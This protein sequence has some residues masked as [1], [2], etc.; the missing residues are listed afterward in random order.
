MLHE[1]AMK[2]ALHRVFISVE[3]NDTM[4]RLA[5][6]AL[7]FT[8]W[9]A[10][11]AARAQAVPPPAP[12]PAP[13]APAQPAAQD[14]LRV[15]LDC[16]DCFSEYL[17]NEIEFVNFVR[18]PQDADVHILSSSQTTGGGGREVVLR[19][20]GVNRFEGIDH[21]HRAL[22]L[23]N[24]TEST[25]RDVILRTVIIGLLDYLAHDGLPAGLELDV[26]TRGGAQL[27]PAPVDDPWNLW[28]FRLSAGG[29]FNTEE[30]RQQSRWDVNFSG[31]RVT[32]EWKISFGIEAEQENDTF[33]LDDD[34]DPFDV[35]QRQREFDFFVAKSLGPHW[36]V[37]VDGNLES[38]TFGNTEFSASLLP[39][40][41][42]S[43][44]P[45]EEYATR[46]LVIQYEAGVER[47]RYDEVTLFGKTRETLGRH[48][49]SL[50]LDQRQPWGSLDA[51]VEW[52]QYLH[53]RSFYRVE[54]NGQV[55]LRVTRG[56]SF[57]IRGDASRIRDQ[58]SLPIRGASPEE[59]LLRLRE[60]QSGYEVG[61]SFGISYSFGS[62]FNN[63]VNPRFGGGGFNF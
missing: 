45:Y 32:E 23:A 15:F 26:S 47:A 48:E 1:D 60:L 50:R 24:D 46:Q 35:V 41:E 19:F 51:G 36:S 61:V 59:V 30:R 12:P 33:E 8:L 37:G 13:Q 6:V 20:V 17:R 9:C 7:F 40:V 5:F 22:T 42:Y 52:S 58:I 54:V 14:A 16:F 10:P 53:D 39:A 34:E 29:S 21:E 57:Q 11:H 2:A 55:S 3:Q 63:V 49:L 44:F 38:S 28:F 43:I 31:D 62:L 27:P 4:P 18:Q 56:L 25:R